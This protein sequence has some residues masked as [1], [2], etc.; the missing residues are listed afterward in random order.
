MPDTQSAMELLLLDLLLDLGSQYP[1]SKF[2]LVWH[3]IHIK[4]Y[5]NFN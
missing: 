3:F 2:N 4:N 1:K 5:C